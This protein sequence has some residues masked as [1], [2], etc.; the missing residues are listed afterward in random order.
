MQTSLTTS[1]SQWV[2]FLCKTDIPVLRKTS[3]DLVFLRRENTSPSPRATAQIIK[4]DPLMTVKLLRHLQQHKHRRQTH[5]VMQVEQALIMLGVENVFDQITTKSQT[6]TLLHSHPAALV[7]LLHRMHRAHIAANYAFEWAVRLHDTHFEEIHTAALLHDMTELL[8]WCYAPAKM[9]EI[10]A[11]QQQ[12]PTL[13]SR[14]AQQK[15]L[16]FTI[17]DLQS[18][19]I[20]AWQLPELLITLLDESCVNQPRVRNVL[21]AVN[22]ARHAAHGWDNAALPDDYHAIGELLRLSTDDVI[23]M[24]GV[25]SALTTPQLTENTQQ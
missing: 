21:L 5:D 14:N 24:L 9:V 2:D 11:L 10:A 8:L 7:Q 23:K 4:Q 25:D 16:G 6:E 20:I 18:K 17:N 12:D 19:L 1:L 22:L 3:N 15:V 13:R